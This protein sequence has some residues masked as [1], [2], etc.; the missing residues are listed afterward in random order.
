MAEAIRKAVEAG[1]LA[2]RAGRIPK[3][4]HAE[5]SSPMEGRAAFDPEAPAF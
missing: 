4:F 1:R 2:H 5:A 3:R